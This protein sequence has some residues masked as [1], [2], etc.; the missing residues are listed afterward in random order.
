MPFTRRSVLKGLA[1]GALAVPGLSR[2]LLGATAMKSPPE[3]PALVVIHLNG[4]P[5]G[6]FNSAGSFLAKGDFGVTHD[7]I[8]ALAGGLVVDA[9]SF[10]SLPDAALAHMA[11]INFQHGMYKHD[12]A[13][14]ALYQ[15]GDRSHL[16][17]LAQAFQNP[18]PIRCAV[19]NS[20]GLPVGVDANPPAEDGARLERVLDLRTIGVYDAPSGSAPG[21]GLAQLAP[22][23]GVAPNAGTIAD[24][25]TSF[26]ASELLVRAGSNVIFTQPLYAG[27]P[28]RQ[29]DTHRDPSGA[30]AR[31]IMATIM[32][33]LRT[34]VGRALAMANRNVVIV[35][36]GEFSRTIV[37]SDHEPGGTATVIGKYVKT[38]TAGPQTPDGAP[39]KGSPAP[40]GLWSYVASALKLADP[41]FGANP[42]PE[43]ILS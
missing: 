31:E 28:D 32:A 17:L 19:V 5:S 25:R 37:E 10:G 3:S 40:A 14:A 24:T 8:R 20:L 34:F 7:N 29:L 1:A 23:Y 35:L 30:Q 4:G 21:L 16:L 41:P 43:L 13:R 18:A 11:A 15:A 2:R 33:P 22:I 26:L 38:G 9:A 12:L 36:V 39:P 6:F 27:R 42:N